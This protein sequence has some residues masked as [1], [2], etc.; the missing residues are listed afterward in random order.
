MTVYKFVSVYF[1]IVFISFSTLSAQ[2]EDNRRGDFFITPDFGLMFGSINRIEISPALGYHL[3]D[4]LSLAAGF[5]YEFYS[6]TRYYAYQPEFKT[7]IYGPR[8]FA[9]YTFFKNLGDYFPFGMNTSL[10]AH[11]ESETSSLERKYFDYPNFPETGRLWYST[12]L[13]GGGISQTATERLQLNILFLWDTG[14]GNITLY[15]NPIIRFGIQ[16][17]F[18][19]KSQ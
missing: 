18:R 8:F 19:P 15:N 7:Y 6:Q 4:K 9:R 14:G 12:I 5:K 10:F 3:T 11:A 13:L 2:E 1:V 17:Y 16:Y